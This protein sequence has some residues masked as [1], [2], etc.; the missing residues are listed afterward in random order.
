MII[1]L[2]KFPSFFFALKVEICKYKKCKGD[3]DATTS[4]WFPSQKLEIAS[5]DLL[6]NLQV[7]C[8]ETCK[9]LDIF[10]FNVYRL[11]KGDITAATF[12]LV[13]CSETCKRSQG[14][15]GRQ[16]QGHQLAG[17]P[18]LI[19]WCTWHISLLGQRNIYT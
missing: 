3:I 9:S 8:S 14:A 2:L 13:L 7:I 11:F 16:S 15:I 19:P 10:F 18:M 1:P 4:H 5:R 17:P 12:P 6:R